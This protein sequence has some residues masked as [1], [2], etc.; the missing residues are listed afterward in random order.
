MSRSLAAFLLILGG[1]V[2][3][4]AG[5]GNR[6]AHLDRTDPYYVGRAFPKLTTPQWVGEDG[7]EAVVVLA[8][9]DMRGPDKWEAYLRPIRFA[10]SIGS[11]IRAT[12]SLPRNKLSKRSIFIAR[13]PS[14]ANDMGETRLASA[15]CWPGDWLRPAPGS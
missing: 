3:A 15:A 5:D 1:V 9:D 8:I 4:V 6:L 11:M 2:P 14:F 7:V 12:A 13:M 10:T